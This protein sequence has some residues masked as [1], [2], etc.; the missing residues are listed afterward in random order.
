[1]RDPI[2][3]RRAIWCAVLG[4]LAVAALG[5]PAAGQ[6]AVPEL[7]RSHPRQ[8]AVVHRTPNAVELHFSRRLDPQA[9]T[10]TVL[11]ACAQ[12]VGAPAHVLGSFVHV[13]IRSNARGPYTVAYEIVAASGP[14]Q[15]S[16]RFRAHAGAKCEDATSS[17]EDDAV[18]GG[19]GGAGGQAAAAGDDGEAGGGALFLALGLS[20]IVGVGGGLLL[21]VVDSRSSRSTPKTTPV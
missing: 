20:L 3:V 8:G 18:H 14:T 21:R 10:V 19:H 5:A 11:D 4:A 1:M 12:E 2:D 9:F 7:E 6:G 16:F 15:N 17:N 13:P